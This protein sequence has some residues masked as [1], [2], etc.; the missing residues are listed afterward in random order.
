MAKYHAASEHPRVAGACIKG[1]DRCRA[2]QDGGLSRG[3]NRADGAGEIVRPQRAPRLNSS[4]HFQ[5]LTHVVQ[6]KSEGRT[7]YDVANRW[8]LAKR[9]EHVAIMP[10]AV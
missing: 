9:G 4:M 5:L 7:D 2:D 1:G 6:H 10:Y 8:K 3:L